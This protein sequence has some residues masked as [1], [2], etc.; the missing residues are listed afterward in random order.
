MCLRY[1]LN[2]FCLI[3]SVSVCVCVCILDEYCRG[4]EKKLCPPELTCPG[5]FIM[6]G[7]LCWPERTASWAQ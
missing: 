2:Y 5:L 1:Q 6:N 3:S 4:H 7:V